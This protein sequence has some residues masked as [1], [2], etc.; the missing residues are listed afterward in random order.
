MKLIVLSPEK[1]LLNEEVSAV[2]LPGAKG[3][4][5]VLKDHASMLTPLV[6]GVVKYDVVGSENRQEME[7]GGGFAEISN[8]EICVCVG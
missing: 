5:M 2:E 7:I 4:F 3:R 1:T 8:D 6:A